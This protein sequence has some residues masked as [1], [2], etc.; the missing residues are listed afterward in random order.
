MLCRNL[1]TT[2]WQLTMEDFI[3]NSF[4]LIKKPD[5]KST[6]KTNLLTLITSSI[7]LNL[8]IRLLQKRPK[9]DKQKG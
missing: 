8:D 4:L 3:E 1:W 7:T 6:L 5:L 2:S 9:G